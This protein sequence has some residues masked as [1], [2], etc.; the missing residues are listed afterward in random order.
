M[1]S[2][3]DSKG[4]VLEIVSKGSR[5]TIIAQTDS[6]ANRRLIIEYLRLNASTHPGHTYTP[7][8]LTDLGAAWQNFIGTETT[9]SIDDNWE[10]VTV[11]DTSTGETKRFGRVKVVSGE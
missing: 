1:R 10:R 5:L 11:E 3:S 2:T 7:Q 6:G 9:E 4:S 8:F